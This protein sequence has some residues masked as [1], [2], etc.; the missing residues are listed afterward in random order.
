MIGAAS[1]ARRAIGVFLA[2][3]F[4][5]LSALV[6]AR[7]RR[8]LAGRPDRLVVSASEDCIA[9][10]LV[11]RGRVENLGRIAT[12]GVGD[13]EIAAQIRRAVAGLRRRCE[14]DVTIPAAHV[15]ERSLDLPAAAESDLRQLLAFEMDRLT[16]FPADDLCFDYRVAA[17]NPET[18]RIQVDVAVVQRGVV[19]R[20]LALARQSGL[21]PTSLGVQTADAAESSRWQLLKEPPGRVFTPLQKAASVGLAGVAAV[22]LGALVY[23]P[24]QKKADAIETLGRDLEVAREEALRRADLRDKVETLADQSR[25]IEARKHHDPPFVAVLNELTRVVPDDTWLFRLQ[26]RDGELQ[27]F[28]YSDAASSLIRTIGGS[29]AFEDPAFRSPVMRDRRIDAERFHLTFRVAAE[30]GTP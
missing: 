3:W 5:E 29:S 9:L 12:K 24:L 28:G 7:F 21:A 8:T 30:E 26:Y 20:A 6:P 22:L 4:A 19:D 10:V 13:D 16:P 14:I 15:M 2:W 11:S 25:F 18:K 1:R 27:A 17:R 23:L